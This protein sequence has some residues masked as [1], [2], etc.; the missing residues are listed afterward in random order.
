MPDLPSDLNAHNQ[1]VIQDF[2]ASRGAQGRPL[3]LTATGK[4]AVREAR[5]CGVGQSRRR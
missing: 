3:L 4:R 5:R 2:R 1:Q